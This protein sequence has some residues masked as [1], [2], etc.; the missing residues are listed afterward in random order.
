MTRISDSEFGQ[1][2]RFIFET[3]GITLTDA[4]KPLVSGRLAKR[5]HACSVKNYGEY[6]R[7]LMSGDL[8]FLNQF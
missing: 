4:K 3:A 5:L 6:F 8:R 1:F 7:L 2:Q